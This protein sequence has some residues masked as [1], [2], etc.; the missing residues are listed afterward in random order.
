[1]ALEVLRGGQAFISTK[2]S[3]PQERQ[4]KRRGVFFHGEK[5]RQQTEQV[6]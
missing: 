1:M 6:G 2:Q 5:I 3:Q 4:R